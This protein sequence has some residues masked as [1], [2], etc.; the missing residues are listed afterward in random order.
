MNPSWLLLST[1]AP[2]GRRRW[3]GT[4]SPPSPSGPF[5]VTLE[6]GESG[7]PVRVV[8]LALGRRVGRTFLVGSETDLE[9]RQIPLLGLTRIVGGL[10]VD[11]SLHPSYPKVPVV[12][13]GRF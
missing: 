10:L 11:E 4:L 13:V 9:G 5:E 3:L 7:P 6:G 12:G 8:A 2:L 1:A